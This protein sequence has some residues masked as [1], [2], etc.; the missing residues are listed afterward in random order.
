MEKLPKDI[1]RK[2]I[3]EIYDV[4]FEELEK[5][6]DCCKKVKEVKDIMLNPKEVFNYD[7]YQIKKLCKIN[8][9]KQYKKS[10]EYIQEPHYVD[11][12]KIY[13]FI[14]KIYIGKDIYIKINHYGY[15]LNEGLKIKTIEDILNNLQ[16]LKSEVK[17]IVLNL[18]KSYK[19]IKKYLQKLREKRDKAERKCS[20]AHEFS[21]I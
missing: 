15:I 17:E 14:D 10:V 5:I 19:I 21:G 20:F 1:L 3:F 2:I 7:I 6:Y 11:E 16:F 13:Y 9:E 4:D 18:I 8:M 12:T